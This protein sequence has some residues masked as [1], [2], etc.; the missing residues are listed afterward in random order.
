MINLLKRIENAE[1]EY[2]AK[3][4]NATE[5]DKETY[6][7]KTFVDV[8]TDDIFLCFNFMDRVKE[9][10]EEIRAVGIKTDDEYE[11]EQLEN[12]ELQVQIENILSEYGPFGFD[13][14]TVFDYVYNY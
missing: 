13:Y 7:I 9:A 5:T 1:Q 2:V 14:D 12:E 6:V 11:Q 8:D 3:N 4:P 10:Q